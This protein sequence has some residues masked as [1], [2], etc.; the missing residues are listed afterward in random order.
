[1][2]RD[3]RAV[4]QTE[5]G[6]RL[7]AE[8]IEKLSRAYFKANRSRRGLKALHGIVCGGYGDWGIADT[9]NYASIYD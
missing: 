1:M 6:P 3:Y 8:T 4:V 7:P 9:Y 5:K 2:S